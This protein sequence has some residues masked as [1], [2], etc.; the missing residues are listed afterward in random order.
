MARFRNLSI[1]LGVTGMLLGSVDVAW[2]C[3]TGNVL[4]EDKFDT[5]DPSWALPE[6]PARSNGPD[7]L[8][9][10]WDPNKS[11]TPLNQSGYYE[12]Y[13]VCAD[14][15]MKFPE[16]GAGS[17]GIA[18][19]GIDST[20]YYVLDVSPVSGQ[21]AVYRSQKGKYL[22]PIK[23]TANE[24]VKTGQG[25][26]NHLSVVVNGNKATIT[27]NDKKVAEFK[28]QPP[29]GGSLPGLDLYTDKGDSGPSTLSVANFE[30]RDLPQ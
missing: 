9:F 21:F 20:N 5:I 18:F 11:L 26:V 8:S 15:S 22:T 2:S 23:W 10:K 1:A 3:G 12:N 29:Q 13:E 6:D 30:V 27:I 28:G 7:G 25:A 4:F 24:A 16:N 19:W 14:V 17:I